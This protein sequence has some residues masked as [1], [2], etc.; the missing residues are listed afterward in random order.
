MLHKADRISLE[1][2]ENHVLRFG[3]LSST[4]IKKQFALAEH[5]SLLYRLKKSLVLKHFCKGDA[6][7]MWTWYHVDGHK[8]EGIPHE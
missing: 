5:T 6:G 7:Q 8:P 4:Q 3:P 1:T 2:I